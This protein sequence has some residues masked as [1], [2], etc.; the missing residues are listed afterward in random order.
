MKKSNFKTFNFKT[1]DGKALTITCYL[2][3]TATTWGHRAWFI[4]DLGDFKEV[5]I[6]YYNRTWE[7]FTY[8]SVLY[9]AVRTYYPQEKRQKAQRVF[10]H[11]QL[12]AIAEHE[13]EACEKWLNNWTKQ[14]NA[15][16][17]KTREHIK[18]SD[19]IIDTIEQGENLLKVA[20]IMDVMDALK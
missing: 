10:I 1:M 15:L 9:K 20:K 3:T 5:K 6:N 13:A 18:N 17:E 7:A 4:D 19:V 14:Y 16:S 12:K 11:K 2:F 8:E